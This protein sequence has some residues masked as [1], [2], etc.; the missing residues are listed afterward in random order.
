VLVQA[1]SA[2]ASSSPDPFAPRTS[3]RSAG[4]TRQSSGARMARPSRTNDTPASSSTGT[5]DSPRR[6]RGELVRGTR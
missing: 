6:S 5:S 2:R 1:H 3:H 4:V